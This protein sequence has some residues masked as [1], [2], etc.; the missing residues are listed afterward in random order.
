[1]KRFLLPL[2][3]IIAIA[4]SPKKAEENAQ[5]H[6]IT[7][8]LDTV[9]VDAGDDIIHLR[10]GLHW[11]GLSDDEK[12]LFIF[13]NQENKVEVIDMENLRLSHKIPYEREGPNGTGSIFGFQ[14]LKEGQFLLSD[15][16]SLGIFDE[17]GQKSY[18]FKFSNLTKGIFEDDEQI[19]PNGVLSDDGKWFFCY[20][21]K[22]GLGYEGVAKLDMESGA[23][24]RVP[25]EELK[26]M[27][28]FT[29]NVNNDS[30]QMK[31]NMVGNYISGH[32]GKILLSN[33]FE[34]KMLVYDPEKDSFSQHLFQSQLTRDF[35][36][37]IP[38]NT[39]ETQGELKEIRNEFEREPSFGKW[40][41][42]P[43]AERF[44]R[45]TSSLEK[46]VEGLKEYKVVLT[47]LDKEFRQIHEAVTPLKKNYFRTFIR[48][49][50]LYLYENLDDELGFVVLSINEN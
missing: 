34:N 45:L 33:T 43:S 21:S 24:K 6:H 15:F 29:V 16:T 11:S 46:E 23:L 37:D 49:G 42:D 30:Q 20:Y 4:C 17:Q 8:Y 26:E 48:E 32:K 18:S 25:V 22:G 50:K 38:K 36:K 27:N 5:A 12:T 40:M 2:T 28:K 41:F 1:M 39:V 13:N 19:L 14:N 35:A 7:F 31:F 9:M 10:S 44:Y 3:L 47:V